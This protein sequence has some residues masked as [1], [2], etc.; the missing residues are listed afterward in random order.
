MAE[1]RMGPIQKVQ[2][3]N[4]SDELVNVATEDT[5]QTIK[6]ALKSVDADQMN[7]NH[8]TAEIML[9]VDIQAES[10]ILINETIS[11]DDVG[12]INSG[13]TFA[14]KSEVVDGTL[15]NEGTLRIWCYCDGKGVYD[16]NGVYD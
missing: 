10:I 9:P 15:W 3:V 7:I 5:L 6:G 14:R 8:K 2:P 13:V 16:G 1:A 12:F 4:N 11:N